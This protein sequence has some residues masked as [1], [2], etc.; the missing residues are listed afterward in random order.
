LATALVFPSY[1][2]FRQPSDP[3]DSPRARLALFHSNLGTDPTDEYT[4]ITADNDALMPPTAL[5]PPK[6]PPYWLADSPRAPEP[7]SAQPGPAPT[8]LTL[9]TQRA[10]F[11]ILNLRDYPAWNIARNGAPTPHPAQRNDGLVVVPLPAGP[12]TID[13]CYNRTPDQTAGSAITLF[14]LALFV[15]TL[16]AKPK[17]AL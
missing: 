12:S 5:H 7:T 6:L 11:L 2:Y 3:E 13:I 14:A 4:P 16:R 17:L 15:F 10:Q 1:H 9:T 8:H